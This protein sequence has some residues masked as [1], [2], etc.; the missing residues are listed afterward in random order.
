MFDRDLD[1]VRFARLDAEGTFG[2]GPFDWTT[3]FTLY[4]RCITRGVVGSVLRVIYGN[5]NRIVQAPGMVAISYEMIHDTRV[6]YTDGRTHIN[7]AI[8]QYLGDSRGRWEGDTLVVE[9]N[10][11]RGAESGPY[12]GWLDVRGSPF[13]DSARF[14]ERFRRPDFGRLEIDVTVDDA[15]AYTKPFTVRINQQI[16]V[17]T[18]MIEFICHENQQFLKMTG[19]Q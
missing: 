4:D 8:R 10:N 15:K 12:D 7:S 9:T 6:I 13:S 19:R 5:G 3:D 16:I 1:F 2:N 14:I 11:V 18:E 17:D